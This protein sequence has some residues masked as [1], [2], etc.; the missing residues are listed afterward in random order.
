MIKDVVAFEEARKLKEKLPEGFESK[1]CYKVDKEKTKSGL[2]GYELVKNESWVYRDY[3]KY[4]FI[5]A[6]SLDE[7]LNLL[8]KYLPLDDVKCGWII[9]PEDISYVRTKE[10]RGGM[11]YFKGTLFEF[12][13]SSY[14]TAAA[15]LYMWLHDNGY[16]EATK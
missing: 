8:P 16:M 15:K 10:E 7:L 14:A 6:A 12:G 11:Y 2:R 3:E 5:P 4:E 9:T 1:L 13:E